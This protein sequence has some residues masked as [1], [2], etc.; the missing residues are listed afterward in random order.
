MQKAATMIVTAF[1]QLSIILLLLILAGL[2]GNKVLV[3][4]RNLVNVFFDCPGGLEANSVR[5]LLL[6]FK[7]IS[8]INP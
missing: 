2:I 4:P 6:I 7:M 3:S 1:A 5:Y 8:T